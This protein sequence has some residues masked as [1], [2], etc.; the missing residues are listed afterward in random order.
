MV[1]AVIVLLSSKKQEQAAPRILLGEKY[2]MM[3]LNVCH[4]IFHSTGSGG[5]VQQGDVRC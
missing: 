4:E 5:A 3:K 1:V 2:D